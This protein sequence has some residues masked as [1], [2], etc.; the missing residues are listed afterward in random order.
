MQIRFSM[1]SEQKCISIETNLTQRFKI[2]IQF[3]EKIRKLFLHTFLEIAYIFGPKTEF[4][5]FSVWEGVGEGYAYSSL[6]KTLD[7]DPKPIVDS[8]S[9]S[10][11][12]NVPT[13]L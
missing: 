8:I 6:G 13:Y 12:I 11:G 7:E 9:C 2:N 10:S 4:G 5:H 1:K 3:N